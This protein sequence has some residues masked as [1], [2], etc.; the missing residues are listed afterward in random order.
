MKNILKLFL[1][2]LAVTFTAS[3]SVDQVG[4]KY[5][6]GVRGVTF[7]NTIYKT[8]VDYDATDIKIRVSRVSAVEA[9]V[10]GLTHDCTALTVFTIPQTVSFAAGEYEKTLV[11][12]VDP[13][14]MAIGV[15]YVFN[16]TLEEQA[17]ISGTNKT[18]VTVA[19]ELPWAYLGLSEF[20][21]SLYGAYTDEMPTDSCLVGTNIFYRFRDCYHVLDPDYVE[22]GHHII[23]VKD[24]SNNVT[25]LASQS[26]GEDY[27][28]GDP[29]H[30]GYIISSVV[31]GRSITLSVKV[32]LPESGRE[33]TS[34]FTEI[35]VLP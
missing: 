20:T 27:A 5:I 18:K 13:N 31:S 6:D 14:A 34:P 1:I 16:L 7:D 24:A 32:T 15:D 22:A 2:T 26:V 3:C 33:F 9:A 17:S 21:S 19:L 10:V 4:E 28:A 11:I 29:I 35:I 25:T 30:F 12:P 8:T 23:I